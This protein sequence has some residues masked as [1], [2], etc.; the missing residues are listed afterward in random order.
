MNNVRDSNNGQFTKQYNKYDLSGDFGIGYTNKGEEFWFDLEDYDKIKNYCW[1]YNQWGHLITTER[2][3]NKRIFLHRLVM[4]PIPK[5]MVVD[6][7]KHLES[8]KQ[9]YDN[10]KE[11]LRLVTQRENSVNSAI[12][13]NN[14]SGVSGVTFDKKRQKWIARIN[15][16]PYKRIILGVFDNF[17]D[18]VKAR[19]EAEKIYYG[20]FNYEGGFKDE[21]IS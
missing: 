11:N 14:T 10:R 7:I 9:K 2:G 8:H 17:N 13:S 3:S 16:T 4:E 6:H 5:E 15:S 18:A 20:Q 19:Q 21:R 1:H 12:H